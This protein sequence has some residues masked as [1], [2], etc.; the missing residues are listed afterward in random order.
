MKNKK[1]QPFR[2]KD[3]ASRKG[4]GKPPFKTGHKPGYKSDRNTEYKSERRDERAEGQKPR[5]ER[6]AKP[7]SKP[8]HKGRKKP[9]YRSERSGEDRQEYKSERRG[10]RSEGQKPRFEREGSKPGSRPFHKGGKKPGYRGERSNEERRE[11]KSEHRPDRKPE[12]K[13]DYNPEYKSGDRSDR[14]PQF[15]PR[16][17]H[18]SKPDYKQHGQKNQER[19]RDKPARDP[20]APALL[21][22]QHAVEAAWINPARKFKKLW[23]TQQGAENFGAAEAIARKKGLTRPE[24][25]LA[26]RHALDNRLPPG[27]VHQG[28]VA[29]VEP[30]DEV[31]L[32]DIIVATQSEEKTIIVMLD[33]VT[34]PH[35]I[36]AVLRSCAAFGAKA[37]ILQKRYA[38]EV[39]GVLAKT[40]SG[41]VEHVPI[42]REVNLARALEELK[43]NGFTCV[44][45]DEH[46]ETSIADLPRSEKTVIVLGA[47]GAG[48]R[49]LVGQTC[50]QLVRLPTGGPIAS[51]NVSNAAAIALYEVSKS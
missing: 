15:K 48:I 34:D 45:L 14:K 10:E 51:L 47:E 11:Y 13:S 41:A 35:N 39:T 9:E 50:T 4:D 17:T 3:G 16:H 43:D 5:F 20:N 12:Y 31:F 22:G 44:G 19:W 2:G 6:G 46:S 33:Q 26:E 1:K 32:S 27:A 8:F 21:Y 42:V 38:P 23:L 37:L 7:G 24:P 29:E 28:V 18:G 49:H 30:L 36:G 25:Q 40:A